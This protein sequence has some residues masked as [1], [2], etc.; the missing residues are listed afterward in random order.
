MRKAVIPAAGYAVEL[1]PASKVLKT[2]LFP[3]MDAVRMMQ[4]RGCILTTRVALSPVTLAGVT[5]VTHENALHPH[6]RTA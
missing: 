6:A 1:Y 3:V 4:S 2:E 5:S